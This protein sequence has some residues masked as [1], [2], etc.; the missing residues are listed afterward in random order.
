[1]VNCLVSE[2]KSLIFLA[3]AISMDAFSVSLT[4]GTRELRLKHIF[5][6]GLLIGLFHMVL[7]FIGI[8]LGKIISMKVG[9]YTTVI[10]GILLTGIGLHMLFSAFS[11][12]TNRQVNLEKFA[13]ISLAFVVSIDSFSIGISL[14]LSSVK[15]LVAL[16]LFGFISMMM[17]WVG[18]FLGRKIHHYIGIY[19]EI[20][21]GAILVSFGLH[22]LFY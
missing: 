19:S 14:G 1:M 9:Y 4:Y 13:L 21:G 7:P 2:I 15:V 3:F 17:T 5:K 11:S 10:S 20:L 16:T 22:I 18:L 12:Q 6:I 8:V